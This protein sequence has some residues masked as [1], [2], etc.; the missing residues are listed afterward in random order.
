M[1]W[2]RAGAVAA[3]VGFGLS[4][5]LSHLSGLPPV[6]SANLELLVALVSV[7]AFFVAPR[8]PVIA[9]T[10]I[11]GAVSLEL[12]LAVH[13]LEE[14]DFIAPLVFPL[15]IVAAGLFLGRGAAIGAASGIALL[16][17]IALATS[18]RH[19]A[20]LSGLSAVEVKRLVIIEAV[21]VMAGLF[22][23]LA[24]ATFNRLLVEAEERRRLEIRLQHL[25]R[26][27]V[28]GQLAGGAAHDLQNVLTVC[29]NTAALLAGSPDADAREL[30]EGLVQASNSGRAITSG[31]LAL[32]RREE[33]RRSV[34]DV[35]RTVEDLRPL[36]AK[37][38]SPRQA[39]ALSAAGSASAFADPVQLEQVVLNLVANARDA[40][41][42]DGTVA[43]RVAVVARGEAA[44][45]GSTIAA[46][47]Q[48]L[49]EVSD[50]GSGIAPE[51]RDRIFEPFETTKPRG[52]GTGL[53]LATV[54]SIAVAS[55][56]CVSVESAPGEGAAFRVFLPE[57]GGSSSSSAG[58]VSAASLAPA[59]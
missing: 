51:L 27:E 10:A 50:R 8:G 59:R 45:L 39:L 54:R 20:W 32:S 29:L 21:T 4:A 14:A 2:T 15:V 37:L 33:P 35:A 3:A 47:L 44:A 7:G 42:P 48:V 55:G 53:G 30:G 16:Y 46:A 41:P 36:A 5:I 40:M 23:W 56:G 9:A 43:V 57:V 24:I 6:G 13:L 26:L 31:L 22:A 58:G 49:I 18:G 12:L 19:G 28:V 17:P 52:Q 11:L 1:L 25:Q 38:L 34:I